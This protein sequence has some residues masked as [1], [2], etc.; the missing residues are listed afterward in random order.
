MATGALDP[1]GIWL[2]G[3]DDER[4]LFSDLL[5]IGQDSVSDAI[6]ADRARLA[7]LE[8]DKVWSGVLSGPCVAATGWTLATNLGAKKNGFAFLQIS[9]TRTGAAITVTGNGDVANTDVATWAAGWAPRAGL[10]FPG[11][12]YDN[13]TAALRV[14]S[15]GIQLSAVGGSGSVATGDAI[16]F[17]AF[18]PLA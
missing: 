5:N 6:G 2:Y 11:A 18:Y 16:P 1:N 14:T 9:A 7:V 4:D 8:A 3:E 17:T 10:I 13:R 15:F 12:A